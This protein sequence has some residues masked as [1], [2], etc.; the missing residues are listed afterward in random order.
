MAINGR[1]KGAKGELAVCELLRAWWDP[2][3]P[4][5]LFK[6]TPS[7]GGWGTK[8]A[9]VAW[10]VSGDVM[11]TAKRFP[12]SCEVKREQNWSWDWLVVGRP[13][14]VWRWWRQC[15]TSASEDG[16]VP[17]LWFRKNREAW[18]VMMPWEPARRLNAFLS[19]SVLAQWTGRQLNVLGVEGT[20]VV[21]GAWWLLGLDPAL[22]VEAASPQPGLRCEGA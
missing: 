7:S 3:E 6:R 14:P 10:A 21:V 4:G 1:A 2:F 18:R 20:P 8:E 12:L 22:V 17:C 11:S 13:S 5:C 16:R 19:D 9:R 15:C